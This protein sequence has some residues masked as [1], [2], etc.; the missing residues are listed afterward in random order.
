MFIS[1]ERVAEAVLTILFVI[2]L[3][4]LII[5]GVYIYCSLSV[6]GSACLDFRHSIQ[7]FVMKLRYWYY[8]YSSGKDVKYTWGCELQMTETAFYLGH[9]AGKR[10]L[11]T[12]I[13]ERLIL[14]DT[15]AHHSVFGISWMF[16][17][18]YYASKINQPV[19]V[20]RLP[21]ICLFLG[22]FIFFTFAKELLANII[23]WKMGM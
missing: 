13:G 6:S 7:S 1:E 23:S 5:L 22:C 20:F 14:A 17:S 19:W 11:M 3:I 12:F 21:K 18:V 8:H 9:N 16:P 15:S 10:D 4:I 2:C